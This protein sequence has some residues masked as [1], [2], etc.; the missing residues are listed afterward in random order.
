MLRAPRRLDVAYHLLDACGEA[1]DDMSAWH[2]LEAAGPLK[3]DD[4]ALEIVVDYIAC[5]SIA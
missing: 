5:E 1:C 4:G 2:T 3:R